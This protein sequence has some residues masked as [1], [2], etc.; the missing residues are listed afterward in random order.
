[1]ECGQA[2]ACDDITM[3]WQASS[4]VKAVCGGR[5]IIIINPSPL[6]S[7]LSPL[8]SHGDHHN[9]ENSPLQCQVPCVALL[10]SSNSIPGLLSGDSSGE[11]ILDSRTEW[12]VMI[13]QTN[14]TA[15]LSY[16]RQH[17]SK[18]L[19]SHWLAQRTQHQYRHCL[20]VTCIVNILIIRNIIMF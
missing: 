4:C 5:F 6:T 12:T 19:T 3:T 9:K 13:E 20:T 16:N 15:T 17:N 18:K 1:M 14:W 11:E 10:L 8:T 7:L 2:R